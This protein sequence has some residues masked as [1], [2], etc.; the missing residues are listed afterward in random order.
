MDNKNKCTHCD[1]YFQHRYNMLR[2]VRTKH[3]NEKYD[4]EHCNSSFTQKTNLVRH[5][6]NCRNKRSL[7]DGDMGTPIKRIKSTETA[8]PISVTSSDCNWCGHKKKLVDHKSY[9][10]DCSVDGRECRHCHRPLPER[11]YSRDINNCDACVVKR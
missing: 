5:L 8:S 4:C 7:E 3:G 1:Q 11:Y 9:C 2:H 6:K 10:F